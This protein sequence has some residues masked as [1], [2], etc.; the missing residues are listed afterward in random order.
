MPVGPLTAGVLAGGGRDERIRPVEFLEDRE[1]RRS[2]LGRRRIVAAIQPRETARD[3]CACAGS[4]RASTP[5]A[6]VV[7]LVAS[8]CPICSQ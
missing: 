7:M 5:L 8:T 4:G 1:V 2:D 6:I 3:G